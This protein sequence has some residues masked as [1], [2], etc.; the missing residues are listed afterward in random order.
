MPS[1]ICYCDNKINV[2]YQKEY[3]LKKNSALTKSVLDGSFLNFKCGK[4]GKIL[5]PEFKIKFL[6]GAEK[7]SI[8]LLPEID[9]SA[10]LLGKIK[11]PK[12]DRVALGYPELV[13]KIKLLEKGLSDEAIE[14]VKFYIY[15]KLDTDKEI[16]IL[17]NDIK[18]DQIEFFVLGLKDNEIGVFKAPFSSYEE[19]NKNL[20][21]LKSEDP[22][23]YILEGPYVSI[24]K[25]ELESEE[26]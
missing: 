18:D 1:I 5:K 21:L 11:I 17:F 12:T 22:Y 24:K 25:I 4:C 19:V 16:S 10:Y 23:S 8:Y 7:Y 14:I 26:E 20:S 2:S 3:E 9:S 15:E 13:E 6:Y